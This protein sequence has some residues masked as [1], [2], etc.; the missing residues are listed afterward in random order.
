MSRTV[1][2]PPP[3]THST[4]ILRWKKKEKKKDKGDMHTLNTFIEDITFR[5][6]HSS[7]VKY[8]VQPISSCIPL[9]TKEIH[10]P[11]I[12]KKKKKELQILYHHNSMAFDGK[13]KLVSWSSDANKYGPPSPGRRFRVRYLE[14]NDWWAPL[15]HGGSF[16]VHRYEVLRY[17]HR[18]FIVPPWSITVHSG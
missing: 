14:S 2:S 9:A 3:S 10:S 6:H 18:I 13:A 8:L 4:G 15:P 7:I 17:K 5:F 16:F 12:V 11:A 1:C